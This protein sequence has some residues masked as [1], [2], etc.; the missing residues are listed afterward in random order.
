MDFD[1][2]L[3]FPQIKWIASIFKALLNIIHTKAPLYN[4]YTG[5][6]LL[7]SQDII[8]TANENWFLHSISDS[9]LVG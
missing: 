5:R 2:C 6:N 8:F 4:W 3:Y 1:T 7:H 9:S